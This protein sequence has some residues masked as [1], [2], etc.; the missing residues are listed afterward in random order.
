MAEQS[1]EID[2]PT[3][4]HEIAKEIVN[5]AASESWPV[6]DVGKVVA[7]VLEAMADYVDDVHRITT[8]DMRTIAEEARNV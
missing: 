7:A 3:L 2:A 8:G 1:R 4:A 6:Y 5:I